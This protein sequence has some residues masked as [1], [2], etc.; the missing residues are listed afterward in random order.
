M[1]Q[2]VKFNGP[3][4]YC[5]IAGIGILIASVFAPDAA[6][7]YLLLSGA[8]FMILGIIVRL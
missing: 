2:K 4:P 3:N 6:Y 1:S 7:G 5:W 8:L